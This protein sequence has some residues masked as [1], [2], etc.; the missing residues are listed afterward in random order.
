MG[1]TD[2]TSQMLLDFA[3]VGEKGK[4]GKYGMNDKEPGRR[5]TKKGYGYSIAGTYGR[6]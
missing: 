3:L 2:G 1:I 4:N 6:V 5:F